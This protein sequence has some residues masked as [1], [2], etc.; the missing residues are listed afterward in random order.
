MPGSPSHVDSRTPSPLSFGAPSNFGPVP[1]LTN[2]APPVQ[3]TAPRY[4]SPFSSP[5]RHPDPTFQVQGNIDWH[6]NQPPMMNSPYVNHQP[7]VAPPVPLPPPQMYYTQPGLYPPGPWMPP[8]PVDFWSQMMPH[9]G[10]TFGQ[11]IQQ[12]NL[13]AVPIPPPP[14]PRN[15]VTPLPTIHSDDMTPRGTGRREAAGPMPAGGD[16][17]SGP[18]SGS[19]HEGD[20]DSESNETDE[21]TRSSSQPSRRSGSS[22]SVGRSDIMRLTQNSINLKY[23]LGQRENLLPDVRIADNRVIYIMVRNGQWQE[24]AYGVSP[25]LQVSLRPGF[26]HGD[27]EQRSAVTNPPPDTLP[28]GLRPP[29]IPRQQGSRRR[30]TPTWRQSSQ[31]AGHGGGGGDPGDGGGN[32]GGGNGPSDDDAEQSD[33]DRYE[34]NR[35]VARA[36]SHFSQMTVARSRTPG[37]GASALRNQ[38]SMELADRLRSV[39]R[40]QVDTPLRVPRDAKPA[41]MDIKA[42]T[43]SG[44]AHYSQLEDFTR[45]LGIHLRSLHLTGPDH[46]DE[47]KLQ[48]CSSLRNEAED[49]LNAHVMA[50]DANPQDW[51]SEDIIVGLYFRFTQPATIHDTYRAWE[52]FEWKSDDTVQ[53]Y[54]DRLKNTANL[55]ARRPTLSDVRQKFVRGLPSR[56]VTRML[57]EK[58]DLV[59]DDL[60]SILAAAVEAEQFFYNLEHMGGINNH[61]KAYMSNKSTNAANWDSRRPRPAKIPEAGATSN[62]T[63]EHKAPDRGE[64]KTTN[65][66]PQDNVR[67]T[68]VNNDAK[69]GRPQ[70]GHPGCPETVTTPA[71]AGVKVRAMG[72]EHDAEEGG[73][74]T[75]SDTSQANSLSNVVYYNPATES[76]EYG[77]NE[78]SFSDS[79]SNRSESSAVQVRAMR[80]MEPYDEESNVDSTPKGQAQVSAMTVAGDAHELVVKGKGGRKMPLYVS[81][82]IDRPEIRAED[83]QCLITYTKLKGRDDCAA[84]TLWDSG[85]TT[86]AVSPAYSSIAQL[87]VKKLR[88]EV[89][90]FLGTMNRSPFMI[91]HKV[92][93]DFE[94]RCVRIGDITIDAIV[95]PDENV[96]RHRVRRGDAKSPKERAAEQTYTDVGGVIAAD[97]PLLMD[98]ED[99]MRY[100]NGHNDGPETGL[101]NKED[102]A[103]YET[104]SDSPQVEDE[105]PGMAGE[106]STSPR[107]TPSEVEE[108][109][110]FLEDEAEGQGFGP[111][112]RFSKRI[113]RV[114]GIEKVFNSAL[115]DEYVH[116]CAAATEYAMFYRGGE[117]EEY[118]EA[119]ET[120]SSLAAANSIFDSLYGSEKDTIGP[121]P[122]PRERLSRLGGVSVRKMTVQSAWDFEGDLRGIAET[123]A[124]NTER[125]YH[126]SSGS[127]FKVKANTQ[128]GPGEASLTEADIPRLRERWY[129]EFEDMMS[130]VPENMPP[131]REVNHEINLVEE[132]KRYSYYAPRC[133]EALRDE[134]RVKSERYLRAEWWKNAPAGMMTQ[135]APL[136]CVRKKDGRLRTVVD[137]R[138]RNENTVRDVTPLPDM[139]IIRDDV[140]RAKYVSKIDLSDAYEQVR[141]IARDIPKTAFQTVTDVTSYTSPLLEIG[142]NGHNGIWLICDASQT[143]VGAMLGQGPSWN[144]CRPAGFMSKKFSSAQHH[145]AVHERETL[146][147]LEALVKWEDKL[148]GTTLH[149]VTD[150]KALEFFHSQKNL[151]PRQWRWMEYMSRFDFDI[152]YVKGEDNKVADCL[153]RYYEFDSPD[154]VHG[155][156]DYVRAD[157]RLDPSG[158]EMPT[159]RAH[160]WRTRA[161][162]VRAM[163]A[164]NARRSKR[165][166]E[167]AEMRD[168]EAAELADGQRDEHTESVDWGGSTLAS[169]QGTDITIEDMLEHENGALE[170]LTPGDVMRDAIIASYAG[171]ELFSKILASPKAYKQFENNGRV[172]IGI[173]KGKLG[174]RSIRGAV[175][176]EAH[177]IVGHY[178][179]QRT[180]E[181]L[182]RF[183]WWPKVHKDTDK[184][185]MSC[186][187]CLRAK[188]SNERTPGLLHTLPVP[189]QPW[190]AISHDFVGPF[191]EVDGKNYLW[192][193]IDRMTSM[194]HLIP[195]NTTMKATDLSWIYRHEI[196]RLHGLP[197]SIVSDR[198]SKFTSRWWRELHRIMA[199]DAIIASRVF[200][201]HYANTKRRPDLDISDDSLVYLST[202]NLSLPKGRARKLVPKFVGPY[203]VLKSDRET[204]TYTLELP[205]SLKERNLHSTF[206]ISVLRRYVPNDDVLFPSRRVPGPYDFGAQP[207]EEVY[208]DEISAHR[209]VD[210]A[211]EFRVHWADGDVEWE[212]LTT[213]RDLEAL[214]TYLA[215]QGVKFTRQLSKDEAHR[216]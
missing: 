66:R 73:S 69:P 103:E 16:G 74:G 147:I 198:D 178:G 60:E 139:D 134:L 150:H 200:Q 115:P 181:Y 42:P 183:Y 28:Q 100:M 72:Q 89:P 23:R 87:D 168:I 132:S 129:T 113:P 135:A 187:F 152:T 13:G 25:D 94:D 156:E 137:L 157:A 109:M 19:D 202:K 215:L 131:E 22:Y 75:S 148:G 142:R 35:R 127:R 111:I 119:P 17:G 146:A 116:L 194:V 31:P 166:Q 170:V 5:F 34:A 61:M 123:V 193:I 10:N 50:H 124:A 126:T 79:D 1:G 77:D 169:W 62:A 86:S 128:A 63:Q 106:E 81:G 105:S 45:K 20:A 212:P 192:V 88:R 138:Q 207:G 153:S 80:S 205:P 83:K 55:L 214:D 47:R 8:P 176:E 184:F 101:P 110:S 188:V 208:V 97:G 162:E 151:T 120:T 136:L 149:V 175:I 29:T 191:P 158:E 189:T 54:H 160:E 68:G 82:T 67:R 186:E 179:A 210:T 174:S 51:T 197:E 99:Y 112:G 6:N 70:D 122:F 182:R 30:T 140:A 41:K 206:H 33:G 2:T 36:S 167:R 195:V 161:V 58:V 32:N 163:R 38:L 39:W 104:K 57:E 53:R 91:E 209:W 21:Q 78:E 85:S 40:Q 130:G 177:R 44:N 216:A 121:F 43:Y 95:L 201:T 173:P 211:L 204:S 48:F 96:Q 180:S 15:L 165:L 98:Q 14:A 18:P 203:R 199:H 144:T 141:I 64:P 159:D 37:S 12:S 190:A 9:L 164:E 65:P 59:L 125:N 133:P 102:N 7:Y 27:L 56:V 114:P 71:K 185:C 155:V 3:Y 196:V 90:L 154:E 213:V 84:L 11:W 26:R 49:W 24:T 171:D 145:Y 118:P 107:P 92:I 143:G 172:V 117:L 4:P 46:D 52:S 108:A 76:F 93:L